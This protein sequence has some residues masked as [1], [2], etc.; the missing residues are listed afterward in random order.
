RAARVKFVRGFVTD[1][2]PPKRHKRTAASAKSASADG[3][4]DTKSEYR[5][6]SEVD[7]ELDELGI[8]GLFRKRFREV[9][10]QLGGPTRAAEQTGTSREAIYKWLDGKARPP[11]I[12]TAEICAAAGRSVDWLVG[13]KPPPREDGA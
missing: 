7:S 3:I 4:L 13:L 2:S 1:M 10:D 9:V 6:Q 12:S 8:D 5:Q 11:L